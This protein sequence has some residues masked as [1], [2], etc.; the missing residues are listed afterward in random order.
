MSRITL[1]AEN[2][3]C[4]HCAMTIRRELRDVAG[5]TVVDVD[6]PGKNIVLEYADEAALQ[7]AKDTL[8]EIGYPVTR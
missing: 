4:Q 2:I 1:H 3:S 5:V 7:R 8:Q 6:V